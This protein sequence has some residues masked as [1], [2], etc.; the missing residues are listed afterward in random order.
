MRARPPQPN[1]H[2]GGFVSVLIVLAIVLY[3][4]A[5]NWRSATSALDKQPEG[6]SEPVKEALHDEKIPGLDVMHKNTSTHEA[7]TQSMR[8]A[9]DE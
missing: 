3:L 9:I 8:Q 2:I 7:R 4:A 1:L 5:S 6:L